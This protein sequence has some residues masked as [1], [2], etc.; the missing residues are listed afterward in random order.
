MC[1]VGTCGGTCS[2]PPPPRFT[3]PP[4]EVR[5]TV[6]G[7]AHGPDLIP[8]ALVATRGQLLS[9]EGMYAGRGPNGEP[10]AVVIPGT[11]GEYAT[12]AGKGR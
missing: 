11:Y 8:D 7:S 2:T 4:G 12:R 10:A 9:Y 5:P 3:R 1:M 6:V